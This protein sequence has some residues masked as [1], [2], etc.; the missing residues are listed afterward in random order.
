MSHPTMLGLKKAFGT[1]NSLQTYTEN[2]Q[3][4]TIYKVKTKAMF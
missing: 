2:K 1:L 4:R 3:A